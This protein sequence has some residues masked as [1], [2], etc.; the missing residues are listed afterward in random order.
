[1]IVTVGPDQDVR[2]VARDLK[3][4][5]L[6]VDQVLDTMNVVTGKADS[7]SVARLKQ[8]RG[9]VD[10]SKDHPVDIGP[11]DSDVS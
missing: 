11:P 10:V 6:S 2:K 5:G 9:V 3:A 4:A 8:V 7:K 1:M